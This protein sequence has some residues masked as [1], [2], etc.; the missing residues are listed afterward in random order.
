MKD[1]GRSA[2]FNSVILA[3][4]SAFMITWVNEATS[5]KGYVDL[6]SFWFITKLVGTCV[7]LFGMNIYLAKQ[8]F[9]PDD[10][11]TRVGEPDEKVDKPSKK[12]LEALK[13]E[14]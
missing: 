4:V 13:G 9:R 1:M 12:L 5:L 7:T 11:L 10:S 14:K 2:T 8:S 3:L 6:V